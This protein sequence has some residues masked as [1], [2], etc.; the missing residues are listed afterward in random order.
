MDLKKR[1][2][3]LS[4]KARKT[5]QSQF[6][7]ETKVDSDN[8]N[9]DFS[10]FFFSDRAENEEDKY[11]LLLECA[12]YADING[13]HA[14][15]VPERHFHEFGALYPS[16]SVLLAAISMVTK[17]LR[18]NSG[19]IVLPLHHPVRVAEE[20]SMLD[21]L[22]KG[23][24]GLSIA[25]GWNKED[26]VLSKVSYDNRKSSMFDSIELIKQLWIGEKLS[27]FDNDNN[28][29]TIEI[30]PK[31]IQ[32]KLPL[33]ITSSANPKT[34]ISA[35]EI[36]ANVL[37]GLMEQTTEQI[38]ANIV[39]YRNALKKN[40]FP[41]NHGK[42]TVMLHT[43]IDDSVEKAK[44][45]VKPALMNYF[46]NHLSLYERQVNNAQ[47]ANIDLNL[48]TNA[49]KE[50]LIEHGFER[51]F[52]HSS[53]L[54]NIDSCQNMVKKLKNIGIDEIAC[55]INFGLDDELILGGLEKLKVL[56]NL[57]NPVKI[58]NIVNK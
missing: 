56:K 48:I 28:N 29:S 11:S 7:T 33:W 8:D 43:Y 24:A 2:D 15:W 47:N 13:F 57:C 10:I 44:E 25:S 30:Y 19:S 58:K 35:G 52:N 3:K 32:K 18:L 12:K 6:L 45:T 20:W 36:G 21:N 51:Y 34:W 41:K 55:L 54:G 22:S 23:R 17:N 42:V 9:L 1:I 26:F 46:R 53:L 31:P 39:L 16:P 14:I 49:D 40:G 5:L 37:S 38:A 50:T 4:P 27:F